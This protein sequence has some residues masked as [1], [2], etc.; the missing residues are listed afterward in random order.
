M[1]R[2]C[3]ITASAFAALAGWWD[4]ALVLVETEYL[5][6]LFHPEL[7]PDFDLERVGHEVFRRA[8]GRDGLFT[9]WADLLG[10]RKWDDAR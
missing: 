1:R 3:L 2:S 5:G 10:C 4:Q 8:Y 7:F 6:A 9:A